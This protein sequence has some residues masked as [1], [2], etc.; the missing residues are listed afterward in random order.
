MRLVEHAACPRDAWLVLFDAIELGI[1]VTDPQLERIRLANQEGAVVLAA[2]ASKDTLPRI[3]KEASGV[4]VAE[5][6]PSERFTRAVEVSDPSGQKYFARARQIHLPLPGALLV[7]NVARPRHDTVVDLLHTRLGLSR[8][9]CECIA[10]VRA[11]LHNHEIAV[12]LGMADGTVRQYLHVIYES[13]EID[14]RAKLV[15]MVDELILPR[16]EGR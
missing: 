1:L 7:V 4:E 9:K 3:L 11:G 2:F 13:L 12:R 6:L 8:R 10:L 5:D 16:A 14:S 15:A